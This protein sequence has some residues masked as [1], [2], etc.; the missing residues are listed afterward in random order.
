MKR[1]LV[2]EGYAMHI[3]ITGKLGSGKSTICHLFAERYNFEIFSTG[4]L[5]RR[6]AKKMGMDTIELNR[7]MST[8][9]KYDKMIDDEVIKISQERPNDRIIF[10]SRLAWH[11]VKKSF[12][13][14]TTIDPVI[15]SRRV[16]S[17]DRGVEERY[18][19]ELDA[20]TKLKIR[21]ELEKIRFKEI[22]GVNHFDYNNYN[23]VLDTTW[24][25]P[26]MLVSIISK[27]YSF[28]NNDVLE[29][30][31]RILISPKSLYPTAP[32]SQL[33]PVQVPNDFFASRPL[34]IVYYDGYHYVVDKDNSLG[35]ALLASFPYVYATLSDEELVFP[36]TSKLDKNLLAEFENIGNFTYA[37]IPNTY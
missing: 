24:D 36:F 25:N 4:D 28:F 13:L 19:D 2:A 16:F 32:L 8:D 37:S 17:S 21:S 30:T 29:K 33:A 9:T 11:F 10:D 20:L 12:K 3:T 1:R 22:Y 31:G 7:L 5:H 35:V 18:T 6:L 34:E 15:A 27:Y 26:S 23:L 14:Y